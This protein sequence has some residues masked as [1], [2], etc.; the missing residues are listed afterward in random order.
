[1]KENGGFLYKTACSCFGSVESGN[2]MVPQNL[3]KIVNC[4]HKNS[5]WQELL[6][7]CNLLVL[8]KYCFHFVHTPDNKSSRRD[9]SH[10]ILPSLSIIKHRS[11]QWFTCYACIVSL[12]R[13]GPGVR[14][15]EN[16]ML[17]GVGSAL[18]SIQIWN[19]QT[20]TQQNHDPLGGKNHKTHQSQIWVS[21]DSV[22][23]RDPQ[24]I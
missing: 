14:A 18:C 24:R 4:F 17:T 1:M 13:A 12:L 11:R 22:L 23:P 20:V 21:T 7:K 8:W 19:T 2:Y 10:S 15:L 9:F 3:L 6:H 5:K 16:T